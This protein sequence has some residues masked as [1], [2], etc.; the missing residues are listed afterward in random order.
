MTF[1][2][3]HP[4]PLAE[5]LLWQRGDFVYEEKLDG[6][7]AVYADGKLHGRARCYKL[8]GSAPSFNATLDGELVGGTFYAFDVTHYNGQD[9][10]AMPLWERR[11][12]LHDL[13]AHFP[14]WLA[15]VPSTRGCGGEF[16]ETVLARGG[17]GVV[18]KCIHSAYGQDWFKAK[19]VQTFDCVVTELLPTGSVRL[20]QYRDGK[21][22][23]CGKVLAR[24]ILRPGAVVEIAAYS[25]TSS[26]KFRE[27]RIVRV[28]TDKPAAECVV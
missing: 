27:P 23:D 19:R 1:P 21:L 22:I 28:R 6:V 13:S 16:L 15:L 25:R 5:A 7:R 11:R 14:P 18:A 20:G 26:G 3:P 24:D 4:I 9:L 8:P 17:E 2:A 10:R 12:V